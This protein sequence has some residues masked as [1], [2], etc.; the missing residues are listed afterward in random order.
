MKYDHIPSEYI[1]ARMAQVAFEDREEVDGLLRLLRWRDQAPTNNAARMGF[2]A[3]KARYAQGWLALC[4]EKSAQLEAEERAE[5][6]AREA[7]KSAQ[8]ER[9]RAEEALD[10]DAW[11][12]AGGK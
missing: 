9:R 5:M 4:G 10:R 11:R 7:A 3:L 1:R 6:E 2:S 8:E 12:R